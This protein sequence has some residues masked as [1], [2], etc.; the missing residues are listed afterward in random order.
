MRDGYRCVIGNIFRQAVSS[1]VQFKVGEGRQGVGSL[2]R[3][4]PVRKSVL[5]LPPRRGRTMHDH[6]Q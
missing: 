6:N 4:L 3:H 1:R 2:D 5:G